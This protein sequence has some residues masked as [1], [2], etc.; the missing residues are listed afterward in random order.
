MEGYVKIF[1]ASV[2][3]GDWK[4][5]VAADN[6]LKGI[7][8]LL[9]KKGLMR[10]TDFLIG[11]DVWIVEN[12]GGQIQPPYIAALLLEGVDKYKSAE[13][14]LLAPDPINAKSVK[15]K[16]TLDEFIGLFKRFSIAM[17]PRGL[18]ITNR[19]IIT[20]EE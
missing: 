20:M 2:Q 10:K 14:V 18:D 1:K 6:D 8:D 16:I 7:H 15:V 17:S 13:S 12:Y 5:T 11:I 19:E 3:Y 9:Q 4:G